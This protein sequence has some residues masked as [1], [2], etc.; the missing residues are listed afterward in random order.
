MN[1]AVFN[2]ARMQL[3]MCRKGFAMKTNKKPGILTRIIAAIL[4]GVFLHSV[5]SWGAFVVDEN[6]N[7]VDE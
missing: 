6:G 7:F 2:Q 3:L 5:G 1:C 4:Q